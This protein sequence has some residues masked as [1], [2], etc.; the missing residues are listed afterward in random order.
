MIIIDAKNTIN[1][2]TGIETGTG[3]IERLIPIL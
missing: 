3:Q 1:E 2:T